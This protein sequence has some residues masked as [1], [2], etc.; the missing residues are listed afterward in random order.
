MLRTIA[1][2]TYKNIDVNNMIE[3]AYKNNK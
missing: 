1:N 3:I 2:N